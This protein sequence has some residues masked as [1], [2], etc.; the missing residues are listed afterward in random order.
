MR[1]FQLDG[2]WSADH[3]MIAER[4]APEP[5]PGQAL[6]RMRAASLN[7]RDTVVLQRGYGAQTGTLPLIPLSDGVGEVVAVGAGVTRVKAGDRACP[8][9]SPLWLGGRPNAERLA[10]ARGG[11]LDGVMAEYMAVDAEG[12]ALA[13]GHLSDVEAATLPCA[14]LTAWSALVTEGRVEPGDRVLI[15]GTGGVSLFALQFAKLLGAF[16]IVTSSSNEKLERARAL[17]A[18]AT[19]NYRETPEWGRGAREIAGGDGVDHIVEVGGQQTLPQSLR[20]IRPGGTISMIGVLSGAV[21]D[22]RLGLVVTRQVRLQG[23]TVG[24]RDSFEAMARAIAQHRLRPVV[25]RVFPF[26]E[27]PQALTYLASGAH[28]GKICISHG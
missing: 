8:M 19:L 4:P 13:P 28:F 15:Q 22:A 12:L 10:T 24:S 20:A 7:Y 16:A 1:V 5:G 21:M 14:A 11:P 18:D 27:L 6:L 26:E 2:G 9:F 17:G 3:L 23:I 25:D